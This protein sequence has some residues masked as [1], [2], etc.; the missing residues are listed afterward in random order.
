MT[1]VTVTQ[2]DRDAAA[3]LFRRDDVPLSVKMTLGY[4]PAPLYDAFARH[5]QSSTEEVERLREALTWY[6]DQMCEGLCLGKDPR[7]CANIG[8]DNCAGCPAVIAL[9]GVKPHDD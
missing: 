8:A 3:A 4:A 6:A 9:T 7:S 1:D 5:R 2:E